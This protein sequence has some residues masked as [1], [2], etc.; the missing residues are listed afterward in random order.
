MPCQAKTEPLEYLHLTSVQQVRD[1]EKL[2]YDIGYRGSFTTTNGAG[3]LELSAPD[4][5]PVSAA[6]GDVIVYRTSPAPQVV[7]CKTW[8][9]FVATF[10]YT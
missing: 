4:A 1:S 6:V 7:A 5:V 9:E 10:D 8:D 3:R 2:L